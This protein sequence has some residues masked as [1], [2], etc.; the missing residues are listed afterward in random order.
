MGENHHVVLTLGA[1]FWKKVATKEERTPKHFVEA[2]GHLP[3]VDVLG[4]FF[5]G[6][7]EGAA[8][9]RVNVLEAG[10]WSS[11]VSSQ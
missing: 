9:K 7:I 8:G 2:C 10:S 11:D 3:A 5:T 1:L 6:N 4:L